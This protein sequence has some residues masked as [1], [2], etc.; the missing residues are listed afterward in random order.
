MPLQALRPECDGCRFKALGS[1]GF[2][3][4]V[5]DRN[6]PWVVGEGPG[7]EEAIGIRT[8]RGWVWHPF[9]GS[10]GRML[11]RAL[12]VIGVSREGCYLT[13][14]T[15]CQPPYGAS[16]KDWSAA[17][18]HCSRAFLAQEANG[19]APPSIV[20]L[21]AKALEAVAGTAYCD[22]E[23]PAIGHWQGSLWYADE[24]GTRAERPGGCGNTLPAL[25]FATNPRVLPTIHPAFIMRG[26]WK[27]QRVWLRDL[28]R[29]FHR[30]PTRPLPLSPELPADRVVIDLE[31]LRDD[32]T[33][34]TLVGAIVDG[35]IHQDNMMTDPVRAALV[36]PLPKVGHNLVGFDL[37]VLDLNF[38]EHHGPYWDT[39][40]L[41]RLDDS[42]LPVA[43]DKCCARR[44]DDYV[45]WKG[46]QESPG[47][48]A[49]LSKIYD[50]PP[51]MNSWKFYNQ[52][53]LINT[54]ALLDALRVAV[55]PKGWECFEK[56]N[57]ACVEVRRDL[58]NRGMAFN[59]EK[60]RVRYLE[61]MDQLA[62]LAAEIM[63]LVEPIW[64]AQLDAPLDRINRTET[65][66]ERQRAEEPA[67]RCGLHPKYEGWGAPKSK[68][69]ACTCRQVYLGREENRKAFKRLSKDLTGLRKAVRDLEVGFNPD[70][71]DDW[72]W[73]LFQTKLY[74]IRTVKTK[75]GLDTIQRPGL[76]R[77]PSGACSVDDDNLAELRRQLQNEGIVEPLIDFRLKWA[78]IQKV[79]STYLVPFIPIEGVKNS[80]RT[81]GLDNKAHPVYADWKTNSGRW[82]SGKME[83]AK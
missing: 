20:T 73:L 15:K 43:L 4:P 79:I 36:G 83:E 53:D 18:A 40:S 77:T 9:V 67:T 58:Y 14:A 72:R 64:D 37:S 35:K 57:V 56:E 49:L 12:K 41:A 71:V 63:E 26:M 19:A 48:F 47:H 30:V 32:P 3:G 22:G 25:R 45:Q 55:G 51:G 29:G 33:T 81:L 65:A 69:A 52:V 66:M 75:F 13:N 38:V 78:E 7:G 31:T 16:P 68:A 60:G 44:L 70:S 6:R 74:G 39:I 23:I 27:W 10:S 82:N 11:N 76:V 80:G 21:G 17:I 28:W 62:Q 34:M 1:K 61:F 50:I 59:V 42:D 54:S 46:A 2:V 8:P 5:G 24:V